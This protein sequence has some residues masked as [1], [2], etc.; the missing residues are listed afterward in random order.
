M[1]AL[2]EDGLLEERIAP[3]IALFAN[4]LWDPQADGRDLPALAH[5]PWYAED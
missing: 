5:S 4:L 3:S 2:V 1:R